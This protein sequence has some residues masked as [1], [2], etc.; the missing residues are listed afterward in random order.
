MNN[1]KL[2]SFSKSSG[3]GCKLAPENL[4]TLLSKLNFKAYEKLLVGVTRSDDA[5]VL[6]L[7]DEQALISTVDFFTP[8][9]DN[10]F[11]FGRI[12]A[13]NSISDIYAMGGRPILA[14]A[15]LGWPI[16]QLPLEMAAEVMSGALKIC[17]EYK[18][19]LAGGHSIESAEPFFGLSVNGLVALKNLKTNS[20]ARVGDLLYL[21]KAVG[22]G[23]LASGLKRD[24]VD[25]TAYKALIE[26]TTSVNHIGEELGKFEWVT[27]M[28]DVTG[29][30]LLGHI[31]EICQGSGVGAKLNIDQV[32][33]MAESKKLIDSFIF[34]DNTFKNWNA[35]GKLISKEAEQYFAILSEPQTNGGLLVAV[36]P[37]AK[38]DFEEFLKRSNLAQYAQPIGVFTFG[39]GNELITL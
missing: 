37:K 32:H 4:K 5:A 26:F 11:D 9:V 34:P 7:N 18:I 31:I 16:S 39:E 30:G 25:S 19:P 13:A 27:A 2:T 20:G 22:S 8:L 3:C 23:S 10:P 33:V 1:I 17:D 35:Y 12:A 14:T 15:I 21:T 29:F 38:N 28:T 24:M 36:S 6:Q